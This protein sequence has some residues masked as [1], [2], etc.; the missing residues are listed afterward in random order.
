MDWRITSVG[1]I[2][3]GISFLLPSGLALMGFSLHSYGS[4]IIQAVFLSIGVVF[5]AAGLI[6]HGPIS[7]SSA[8]VL[9]LASPCLAFFALYD[10]ALS[11]EA[12]SPYFDRCQWLG[13]PSSCA[14]ANSINLLEWLFWPRALIPGLIF[15][16]TILALRHGSRYSST[17]EAVGTTPTLT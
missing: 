3:D 16:G 2:V 11:A 9:M 17:S 10:L 12:S 5:A 15:V 1:L 13:D 4:F 6:K 8:G 14:I 7:I